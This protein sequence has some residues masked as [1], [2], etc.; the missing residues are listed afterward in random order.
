MF[1]IFSIVQ[2]VK[3]SNKKYKNSWDDQTTLTREEVIALA[4]TID[5]IGFMELNM[6]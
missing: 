2:T 6:P 4:D 5:T 3:P 1:S